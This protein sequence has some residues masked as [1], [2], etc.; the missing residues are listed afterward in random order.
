VLLV[1]DEDMVRH[2]ASELL[3]ESGYLVLSAN[4]GEEAISFATKHKEQIDLLITDVVMP[5]ISGKEV[6][7]QLKKIHPETKVLFMSG[8]TDE[9]IVHHGIV[10]SNIAFI[11]KPFSEQALAHKIREVLDSEN[12]TGHK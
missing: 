10:D 9:A 8:Y 5:N 2:L 12:G 1:E 6:A 7:E 4:G 3:E 11:Q